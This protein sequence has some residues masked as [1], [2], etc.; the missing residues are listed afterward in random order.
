M[1]NNSSNEHDPLLLSEWIRQTL[2]EAANNLPPPIVNSLTAQVR[3]TLALCSDDYLIPALRVAWSLVDQM[4]K[5]VEQQKVTA[6]QSSL[7]PVPRMN[8][9]DG[10]V[11]H[12][13]PDGSRGGRRSNFIGNTTTEDQARNAYEEE[14]LDTIRAELLPSMFK[15]DNNDDDGDDDAKHDNGSSTTP[16][17]YSL[18]LVF[19]E[20][21]SGGER[22]PEIIEQQQNNVANESCDA[23]AEDFSVQEELGDLDSSLLV[24][25]AAAPIIDVEGQLSI[26]DTIEDDFNLLPKKR[27]TTENSDFQKNKCGAVSVEPLKGKRVPVQLCDL[28]ANMIDCINGTLSGDDAYQSMTHVRDDL[29]LMLERPAI[30]LY[31]QDMGRLSMTGL[32]LGDTVFG[33]NEKLSS[34]KECYRRSISGKTEFAFISGHAGIGKSFLTYEFGKHVIMSGGIFLAGKF[35]QLQQGKPFSALAAAFNGY[36]GMLMQSSELQKRRA[37]VAS[38]LKSSLGREAYYLTKIIP[39]LNDILGSE[40]SDETFYDDNCVDAQRRLQYLLCQFV[41][42]LSSSYTA[43]VTLFLDDLQWA[44]S[45][46]IAAVTQLLCSTGSSSKQKQFFFVGCHREG[47]IDSTHP[48]RELVCNA[49][50]LGVSFT[51]L[52][53]DSMGEETLNAMVSQTLC[54]LPRLTRT[55]SNIIYRKTK[56][57]PLFVSQLMLSLNKKNLLFPSLNRRRWEW[58]IEKI[59]SQKLPDDVAVFFTQSIADLPSNVRISLFHISCF[60]A[61]VDIAFVK[62]LEIALEMRGLCDNL[63]VAVDEGLLEKKGDQLRFSHDRIQ[64]AAY[65]TLPADERCIFHHV[66][67]M[68]LA[69]YSTSESDDNILLAAVNQIN[70]GGPSAIQNTSQS[71]TIATVN[72]RAGQK[73]MVMS[74]F[75]AAYS[76]FNHGISFLQEGYWQEHYDLSLELFDLAAK[77]ALTNGDIVSLNL[78]SEQ[79]IAYGRSLE[80]KLNVLYLVTCAL[81]FSSRLPESIQKSIGVLTKLG[82]DLKE[83]RSTEACIQETMTLL[84]TRTDDEILNTR[85]MTD[86]TMIVAMKFLT[87]LESSMSQTTPRSVPFVTQQII[88]LS[89]SKGM[90]PMS[91]IGFVYLGGFMSKR[92]DISS[93]YRYVK[94][95]L[96]LLDKVGRE[97]A[98]EVIWMAT[99]VKIFVEPIQAANEHHNDGYEASMVAGDVFNALLN[100]F[101]KNSCKY[102]AGVKL[103]TMREEYNKSERLAKENNYSI[104]LVVIKQV[105]RDVLRLI[106]SDEEVTIPEEEILIASNNSVL[107]SYCFRNAHISFMF[108]SYDDAKEYVLKFYECRENAWANLM[109]THVNHALYTGLISFWVAR[110]SRDAQ[111]WIARGNESKLTL[112]RW[113]ESSPW[114]FENKWYLL[115][116]EESF[117]HNDY[118]AAKLFYK[119]AISSAKFHKFVHEEA[120]AYELAAY[121]YLELGEMEQ[122][123]EYFLAAHERYHEWGAFGKCNSLFEFVKSSFSPASIESDFAVSSFRPVSLPTACPNKQQQASSI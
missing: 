118:E 44:D 11:V 71:F 86:P 31:D 23:E 58:D 114:T 34:L 82:I 18:G 61:S 29:Q 25:H 38:T 53:L 87:K 88:E 95:A 92:G 8:W 1:I 102:V 32:Q 122:S 90:S 56:G 105:Q 70:L 91:P 49:E 97:C 20:I 93:G 9:V 2:N 77:C 40:Q 68:A 79:V 52:K 66:C 65:N 117:S 121:F 120:L 22:P 83:S 50:Q 81:A 104:L 17:I 76:Y 28:I 27:H 24:N 19:Y 12:L 21:F 80:D 67:G 7:L 69:S 39:S 16:H 33:R 108:R 75:G 113:A 43:P 60:G 47:I 10:I 107:K 63:D 35:D 101:L 109:V 72:L 78:L 48:V 116:A 57:N 37:V 111:C 100:A 119:H 4:C 45:A 115:E 98:G 73:A 94:L 106:G 51:S 5:K 59:M 112:K 96:S 54:V 26:F 46:S 55:L 89:L 42:V 6:G 62:I 74:D 64:E 103:Q 85:Q 123:I 3:D 110:K 13:H 84:S 99:Q 30:Y 41:E 15:S 36:C 14:D